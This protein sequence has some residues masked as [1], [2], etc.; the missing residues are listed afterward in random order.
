MKFIVSSLSIPGMFVGKN[1]DLK[2]HELSEDEFQVLAYDGYSC[3]GQED[4]AQAT[5]FVLNREP[6]KARI[7]DILLL[8]QLYNGVLKFYCIQVLKS[9]TPLLREEELEYLEMGE[10]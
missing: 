6:V 5:G 7:G 8:A 9:T 10:F 4:I 1:F 3:I 2:V